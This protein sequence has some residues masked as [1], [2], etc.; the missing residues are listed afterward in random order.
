[1]AFSF[2][3]SVVCQSGGSLSASRRSGEAGAGNQGDCVSISCTTFSF[4]SF[5]HA[6][7]LKWRMEW[8]VDPSLLAV[9]HHLDVLLCLHDFL[10][11]PSAT[12]WSHCSAQC[13]V[14]SISV[15][16]HVS[17][18]DSSSS[19]S[20]SSD[21]DGQQVLL[22]RRPGTLFCLFHLCMK[23]LIERGQGQGSDGSR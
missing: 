3:P 15:G 4:H 23:S 5:I 13:Y 12:C 17:S 14:T 2:F 7:I 22:L 21:K 20:S 11:L 16:Y 6:F 18:D 8:C 10:E 19:F 1:M 9:H